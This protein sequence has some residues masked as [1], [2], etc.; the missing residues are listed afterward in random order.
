MPPLPNVPGVARLRLTWSS[1]PNS[2]IQTHMYMNFTGA[3]SATDAATWSG[4]LF[5]AIGNAWKTHMSSF[6]HLRE[7]ELT[8]LTSATGVQVVH[9]GD[10]AGL[11]V[12]GVVSNAT[13]VVTEWE[14]ARR[15]R[16]GKARTYWPGGT[17]SATIDTESWD[18]TFVTNWTGDFDALILALDAAGP[19]AIGLAFMVAVSYFQGFTVNL[20]PPLRPQVRAALRVGG[21][22]VD[23][24]TAAEVRS[25][26]GTQRRRLQP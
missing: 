11:V 9:A 6:V 25:K 24:I 1:P 23:T 8:D 22:V 7:L 26:F 19:G 20:R 16:G 5:N 18:P 12:D 3:M 13:C 14:I 2:N 17:E 10:I 15:Y 4:T 21:P